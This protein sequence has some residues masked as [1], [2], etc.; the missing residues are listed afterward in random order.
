MAAERTG[1]EEEDVVGDAGDFGDFG[2]VGDYAPKR[3]A[4]VTVKY[5]RKE[6]QR[7]LDVEKW[8]DER[9]VLL[10]AGQE[11]DM[12]EDVMIDQ[13]IDLPDDV[14]RVKK[15]QELFQTCNNETE[16]FIEELVEKLRGVHKEEELATEGVEHP[17]ITHGHHRSHE[18]YHFDNPHHGRSHH[19]TL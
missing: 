12:P 9:L 13:L 14:E 7:R 1:M 2:D 3:H 10:Y 4:R 5:N 18:P 15:L 17:L 6:L 11:Q 8:I 19:Q 16:S